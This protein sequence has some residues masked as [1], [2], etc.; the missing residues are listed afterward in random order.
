VYRSRSLIHALIC[1]V[2]FGGVEI[3]YWAERTQRTG[4]TLT[5]WEY[6]FR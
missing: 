1:A 2:V 6:R 3:L 5:N 4:P